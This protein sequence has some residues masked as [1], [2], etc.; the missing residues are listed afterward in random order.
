[1]AGD[2]LAEKHSI[3]GTKLADPLFDQFLLL[4]EIPRFAFRQGIPVAV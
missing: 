4:E 2:Q 1:V 3:A